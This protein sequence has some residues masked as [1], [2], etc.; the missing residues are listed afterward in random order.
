MVWHGIQ[1]GVWRR[2]VLVACVLFLG[3]GAG[4][5]NLSGTSGDVASADARR[6]LAERVR[7]MKTV[8]IIVQLRGPFVP[9]GELKSTWQV[10]RQREGI[11]QAQNR[12]LER[13]RALGCDGVGTAKRFETVPQMGLKVD[14]AC[15]EALGQDPDVQSIQEDALG[16][17]GGASL[18]APQ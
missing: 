9:E 1:G 8:R 7:E 16:A 6:A 11:A 12:V 2:G 3:V 5:A 10:F 18:A 17:P 14:E 15:L 4:E 13:L